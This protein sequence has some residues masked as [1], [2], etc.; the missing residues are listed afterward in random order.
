MVVGSILV[1]VNAYNMFFLF[2]RYGYATG[3]SEEVYV[4]T[5]GPQVPNLLSE[6][7][8]KILLLL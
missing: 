4:N 1:W 6:N 7:E 3:Y 8:T 2:L 5:R